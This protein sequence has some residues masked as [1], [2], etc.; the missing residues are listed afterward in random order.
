LE[1]HKYATGPVG[2]SY[3]FK[4]VRASGW[5]DPGDRSKARNALAECAIG[6]F[7]T[8]VINQIGPWRSMREVEWETL[9]WVDW[10]NNRRLFRPIG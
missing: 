9:K 5:N 4:Q 6:L 2:D 8:G 3:E 1:R 10:Y 7:K